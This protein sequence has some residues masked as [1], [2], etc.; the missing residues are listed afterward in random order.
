[1]TVTRSLT[2]LALDI[3]QSSALSTLFDLAIAE[4]IGDGDVT[5][6]ALVPSGLEAEARLFAKQKGCVAGLAFATTL[7]ERAGFGLRVI[8]AVADGDEVEKGNEIARLKG[9]AAEILQIERTLLNLLQR[10]SGIATATRRHREAVAGLKVEILETRKTLPGW[11]MLDKYAVLAGGGSLHR[12]GLFD[13]ILAKENHFA[14]AKLGGLAADFPAA[15]ALLKRENKTNCLIEVEVE[16]LSEFDQAL[17]AELDIIL[18]D[19]MSLEDM[20]EAVCRRNATGQGIPLLEAS[21]GITFETLR[22]VAETGV[23]RISLGALTHSVR[24]LDISLLI[25]L[26][27]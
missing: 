27:G 2:A 7:I 5:T 8:T 21:G 1:M 18:L 19:N 23:D 25:E 13:Q 3:N 15:L 12:L 10:L 4:D 22:T 6:A 17:A 9:S 16:D 11:R 24:A 20:R 14:L 26:P